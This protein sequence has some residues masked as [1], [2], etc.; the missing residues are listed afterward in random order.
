MA[1]AQLLHLV[2]F[3][4]SRLQLLATRK[5]HTSISSLYRPGKRRGHIALA[6]GTHLPRIRTSAFDYFA[7]QETAEACEVKLVEF[8]VMRS[9]ARLQ[10]L[11][12]N[13]VAGH[14]T[15]IV[16]VACGSQAHTLVREVETLRSLDTEGLGFSVPKVL[17]ESATADM[18]SAS[19]EYVDAPR[20]M[21]RF[22]VSEALRLSIDL[23]HVGEH[24]I[25]H[26]DFAPWNLVGGDRRWLLD[27][28]EARPFEPGVDLA[29]YLLASS[30]I[31]A[32]LTR[33]TADSLLATGSEYVAAYVRGAGVDQNRTE[34]NI[35]SYLNTFSAS[36]P[37]T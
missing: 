17:S 1:S 11:I 24:G 9:P 3:V 13:E 12:A 18:F 6:L 32:F 27:W 31:A 29:H 23:A 33:E 22:D 30:R 20:D 2:P 36:N 5:A 21:M 25:T 10:W 37:N 34:E 7:L 26:G 19:I 4:P 35:A 28:E 16:K 14:T 8:A 15:D